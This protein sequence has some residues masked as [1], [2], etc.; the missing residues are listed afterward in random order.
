[1]FD[2]NITADISQSSMSHWTM[3]WMRRMSSMI[4]MFLRG[5]LMCLRIISTDTSS[6]LGYLILLET[7]MDS[8]VGAGSAPAWVTRW[9]Q[10]CNVSAVVWWS[11]NLSISWSSNGSNS[12]TSA[13]IYLY[14]LNGFCVLIYNWIHTPFTINLITGIIICLIGWIRCG[15]SLL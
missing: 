12:N 3:M 7:L 1:M 5:V 6:L 2:V 9:T 11:I 14:V 13:Y 10:I 15:N 4:M 8:W